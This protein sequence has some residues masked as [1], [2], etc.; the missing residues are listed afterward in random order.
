MGKRSD[1]LYMR[2][3]EHAT[4]SGGSAAAH[5]YATGMTSSSGAGAARPLPF[6]C[7][8]L[9]LQPFMN[10]V[11]SPEG[12]VF[13][14]SAII[15]YLKDNPVCPSTGRRLTLSD[16]ITLEVIKEGGEWVCPVTLKKFT[17][18]TKACFIRNQTPCALY[19]YSAVHDLCLKPKSLVDLTTGAKFKRSDIVITQDPADPGVC[20]RRDISSFKFL[21]REQEA[22]RPAV[23]ASEG[24]QR[25]LNEMGAK[26]PL[27]SSVPKAVKEASIAEEEVREQTV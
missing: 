16:L 17:D 13:E 23:Q 22:K 8:A 7:C 27:S 21:A 24:L 25:V 3:S 1:K 15:P 19:S 18:Q 2:A 14:A 5:R 9:T 12:V 11:A 6:D 4:S 10:P 20:R 26:G